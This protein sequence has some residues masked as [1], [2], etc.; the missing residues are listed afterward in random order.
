MGRAAAF[1]APTSRRHRDGHQLNRFRHVAVV[2]AFLSC[3]PAWAQQNDSQ[4][5]LVPVSTYLPMSNITPPDFRRI[6]AQGVAV[7]SDYLVDILRNTENRVFRFVQMPV[8]IYIQP[9]PNKRYEDAAVR[10][11]LNWQIRSHGL[12]S[13]ARVDKPENARVR[14]SW[15]YLGANADGAYTSERHTKVP[16]PSVTGNGTYK[17]EVAPQEISLNLDR[18]QNE[19]PESQL[20]LVENLVTHEVGH[21]LG[22]IGHSPDRGDIMYAETDVFSRISQRDLNT[23]K[24]L[25]SLKP[26]AA[27]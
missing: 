19:D 5:Q 10:G 6:E 3:L 21:A 15:R 12:V 24:H 20:L 23:L 11:Y 18:L 17:L 25:Y 1:V 4:T 16:I 8:R 9:A 7:T 27:L 2:F 22:L 26:T 13:F 14:L